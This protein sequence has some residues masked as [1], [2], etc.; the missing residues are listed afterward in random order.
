MKD[1]KLKEDVRILTPEIPPP[2]RDDFFL[3]LDPE[4][5]SLFSP[6][7]IAFHIRLSAK[8]KGGALVQS[9]FRPVTKKVGNIIIAGYDYFS[10]FSLICGLITSFGLDILSGQI[11]TFSEASREEG[12]RRILDI[13]QV[14]DNV[15]N[16]F[17]QKAQRMFE[18][19][20]ENLVTL[21][22]QN[23]LHRARMIVNQRVIEYLSR[24][25]TPMIRKIYPVRIKFNN[26]LSDQ[27]T[28]MEIES[29]DTPAFLYAFSNA[30]SMQ[31]INIDKVAIES[32][33]K[34]AHDRIFISHARGG[35]VKGKQE[36]KVLKIVTSLTK[37]FTYFLASSPNPS[38]GIQFFDRLLGKI[39]EKGIS[40]PAFSFLNREKNL[41]L[42]AR[43][44]GTSEFLFE[45]FLQMHFEDLL[46]I[47]KNLEKESLRQGK[48][49]LK[50]KLL[51]TLGKSR[52]FLEKKIKLN[53]FKD[54]E[55]FRIDLKHLLAP[56]KDLVTFSLALTELA[57]VVLDEA[58]RISFYELSEQFGIPRVEKGE[59][60]PFAICGLGKFG[61]QEM[62]YA[63]DIEL[64][65]VYGDEGETDGINPI[66]NQEFYERL[67]QNLL[68]LIEAKREGI[69]HVDL[70]L[71]P[72]GS[73][74]S[75]ASALSYLE[76][77]F[78]PEGGAAPFERQALTKLRWAAGDKALGGKV[79]SLRDR[80]TYSGAP[81]DLNTALELRQQQ[82]KELVQPGTLNVKQSEGGVVDLEYAVQYL[83]ILHGHDNLLLRTPST[84]NAVKGLAQIGLISE[85]DNKRFVDVYL[86]LRNLIDALRV[87][88]GNSR[89]LI[90]PARSSE[91]FKF[92]ARRMGYLSPEWE[93]GAK[94][95]EIDIQKNMAWAHQF[96]VHH[97]PKK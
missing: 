7:E 30:L 27:Y 12:R 39:M 61:G 18:K 4:Y 59:A 38:K 29:K 21:L 58:Y 9:Q 56:K 78:H 74:G 11:F 24:I 36:E 67:G 25:Q 80:F 10:E 85:K 72:Y 23:Q 32:R 14:S 94:A 51:K 17:D 43:L 62:G 79:E 22:D 13:F 5:F 77:Y 35:A 63:S 60:C 65:L 95:L 82:I 57:E 40:G 41:D 97:F 86:F 50:Q 46:P 83:Q 19:E 45:D 34:T 69:F 2:F 55:L 1:S 15:H 16:R 20:L 33:G 64:L 44:L 68:N 28:L 53:Q 26:R 66:S 76:T 90:L 6:N 47:L 37:Q 48:K 96:F 54:R 70:R 31:N 8:V 93:K 84:L 89:D 81:W 49:R 87:V 88:R 73:K 3:H 42:L 92:L 75:L 52:L 71:R 91:E